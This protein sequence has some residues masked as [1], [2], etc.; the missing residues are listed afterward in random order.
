MIKQKMPQFSWVQWLI[1]WLCHF[2]QKHRAKIWFNSR[3]L[4]KLI[5]SDPNDLFTFQMIEQNCN[6]NREECFLQIDLSK[7]KNLPWATLLQATSY[8]IVIRCTPSHNDNII[9]NK[10]SPQQQGSNLPLPHLH[11]RICLVSRVWFYQWGGVGRR[12]GKGSHHHH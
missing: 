6:H 5:S 10:S 7:E 4:L 11:S 9:N 8:I 1:N 2:E 12:S 3:K